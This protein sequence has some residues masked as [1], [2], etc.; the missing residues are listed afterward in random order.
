MRLLGIFLLLLNSSLLAQTDFDTAK[1]LF[2]QKKIV[3]AKTVFEKFLKVYPND[4]P[5]IEYLGD[6][7][8]MQENWDKS[9]YYYKKLKDQYPKNANYWYK[10]GGALGMK[11]KSCNKF[12]ALGMIS[13]VESSFINAS[14]LDA[15]HVDSRWA[16][17]YLYLE[18]PG[19]LGGSEAKA[20]KYANELMALSQVDGYLADGYI[21]EYSKKYITAEKFYLKA[22]EIGNSKVTYQKL[23][24]LYTKKL[25]DFN[26]AKKLHE[27]YENKS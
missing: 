13:D 6:I 1:K 12:K 27:Q 2:E 23:H 11:A 16:L 10:Y 24:D 3:E 20:Q 14:K 7:A 15:K 17:V 8:G 5:T 18:L 26:K 25:K 21:A 19:I 9:I 22:Y 4:A